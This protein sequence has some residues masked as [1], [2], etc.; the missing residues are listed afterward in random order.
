MAT[1]TENLITLKSIKSDIQSAIIDKGG[2]VGSDFASYAQAIID[3][4]QDTI[5]GDDTMKGY[6]EGTNTI[7]SGSA[8]YVKSYAFARLSTA[9]SYASGLITGV[10]LPKASWIGSCAFTSNYAISYAY[11]PQAHT[12]HGS[13]LA[14]CSSLSSVYAPE[15]TSLGSNCFYNCSVSTIDL[16]Q[17]TYLGNYC[18]GFCSALKSISLPEA[19]YL[20]AYCFYFCSALESIS[21]SR[22][23]SILTQT[24]QYCYNLSSIFLN[25]GGVISFAS[26][27]SSLYCPF[28]N[29]HSTL[30]IYVPTDFYASYVTTYTSTSSVYL[31]GLST[32]LSSLFVSMD[33]NEPYATTQ[34]YYSYYGGTESTITWG[35]DVLSSADNNGSI[36][37]IITQTYTD[38]Y[39]LYLPSSAFYSC[40][41]LQNVSLGNAITLGYSCFRAC[42]SL[43]TVDLPV[44][45][46]LGSYCFA[47]CSALTSISLPKASSLGS[48]CFAYCSSLTS[49]S[50]P[51]ATELGSKCFYGCSSL[52][53]ISLPEASYIG[54]GCFY[55]CRALTSISL[56]A[57]TELE[58]YCFYGCTALESVS[59]P[60]VTTM[61]YYG[62]VSCINLTSISLPNA[63]YI[64][65]SCFYNCSALK[66]VYL[67][68]SESI[69]EF[70]QVSGT[71]SLCHSTLQIYVP[72]ALYD[73]YI[74]AY[75]SFSESL[76][77]LSGIY[78]SQLFNSTYEFVY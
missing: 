17:A 41:Y 76:S 10:S 63:T 55:S 3:L 5:V 1:I 37:T 50:L 23:D 25:Y 26:W 75:G 52:T 72:S 59:L 69:V 8:E 32:R 33:F 35:R 54:N 42:S 51:A 22:T 71:F 15:A 64:G 66:S 70:Q 2:S 43:T 13:C 47:Y 4:P 65:G 11:L 28:T 30:K 49:I 29:C 40:S 7:I 20:G 77:G 58:S 39:E 74:A 9:S 34:L 21:L 57:A 12:L 31:S 61:L 45:S 68:N 60:Q 48:Y 36:A 78:Y 44:A 16:P 46:Y 6:L 38:D 27:S 56:P 24:F 14:T 67:G 19:S 53:S 18:F 62:F 73:D